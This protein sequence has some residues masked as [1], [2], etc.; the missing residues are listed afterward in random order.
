M[1]TVISAMRKFRHN[2]SGMKSPVLP[3]VNLTALSVESGIARETLSR[4]VNG[5][6]SPGLSVRERLKIAL[7]LGSLEAVERWLN[8][9]RKKRTKE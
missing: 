1:K 3:A 2:G 9:V 5:K 4:M 7:K 6:N 8:A